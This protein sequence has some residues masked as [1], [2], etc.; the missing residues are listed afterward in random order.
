MIGKAIRS[1]EVSSYCIPSASRGSVTLH[2][3]DPFHR[4]L[5]HKL[6][7]SSL[8]HTLLGWG[9][10]GLDLPPLAAPFLD[11]SVLLEGREGSV[12]LVC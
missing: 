3:I 9:L 7:S 8:E 6:S 12:Y 4:H 1:R 2:S 5:C 10:R 11:V